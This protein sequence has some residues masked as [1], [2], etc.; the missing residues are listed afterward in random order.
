MLHADHTYYNHP[1]SSSLQPKLARCIGTE[2]RLHGCNPDDTKAKARKRGDT[3][4]AGTMDKP[5]DLR[6]VYLIDPDDYIW[7]PDVIVKV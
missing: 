6:E 1:L 3:V 7:V 4:L 5:H 2:I